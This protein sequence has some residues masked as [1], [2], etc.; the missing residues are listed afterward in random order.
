MSQF[1]T[2]FVHKLFTQNCKQKGSLKK[3]PRTFVN[4]KSTH[5]VDNFPRRLVAHS[6]LLSWISNGKFHSWCQFNT[7]ELS[8]CHHSLWKDQTIHSETS[9]HHQVPQVD[10]TAKKTGT[11]ADILLKPCFKFVIQ[12]FENVFEYKQFKVG[13]DLV[14][15]LLQVVM[16]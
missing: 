2:H 16:S 7:A 10:A 9:H 5:N 13:R 14:L 15:R 6:W 12:G 11:K 1:T 8:T 3:Q 4:Y